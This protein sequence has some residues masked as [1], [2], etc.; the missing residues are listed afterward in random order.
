MR[1]SFKYAMEETRHLFGHGMWLWLGDGNSMVL[2][3]G[4]I[5]PEGLYPRIP[6]CW[7]REGCGEV[8]LASASLSEST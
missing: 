4:S 7:P 5:Q 6:N 8:T 1:Q 2:S 3:E